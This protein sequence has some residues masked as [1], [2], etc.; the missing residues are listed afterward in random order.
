MSWYVG[1]DPLDEEICD[2]DSVAGVLKLYF[3]GMENPLFP[4]DS[5]DQ[6]MECG[7]KRMS[8]CLKKSILK[9]F[10]LK[11]TYNY[12]ILS[13]F[14][15]NKM[16]VQLADTEY[17]YQPL[18]SFSGIEDDSEKVAQL[19]SV[20]LSYPPPLVVVMRYLFAFLNQ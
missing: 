1:D 9:Y 6:L 7:R 5:Y 11:K 19:K 18:L 20:I 13:T 12:H 17:K 4:E 15:T 8:V 14:R 2:L 10:Q 16:K 3:R